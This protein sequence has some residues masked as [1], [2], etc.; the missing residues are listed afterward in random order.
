V[1]Q[2]SRFSEICLEHLV[3]ITL[4]TAILRRRNFTADALRLI[5]TR[6]VKEFVY[7]EPA[8]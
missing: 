7:E 8:V 3:I 2:A 1:Q 5:V 4:E 6:E